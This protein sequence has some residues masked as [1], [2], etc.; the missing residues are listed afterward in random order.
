MF[1]ARLPSRS[2]RY[3]MAVSEESGSVSVR[4]KTRVTSFRGHVL[5]CSETDLPLDVI[6]YSVV[7]HVLISIRFTHFC[8]V[9]IAKRYWRYVRLVLTR[10]TKSLAKCLAKRLP[11]VFTKVDKFHTFDCRAALPLTLYS[12]PTSRRV[13]RD[14]S[15]MR[16]A[17]SAPG[18]IQ[19]A[20]RKNHSWPWKSTKV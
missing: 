3:Q 1:H 18:S 2:M 14:S 7:E 17:L 9:T 13:S 5:G 12:Q 20:F 10:R 16:T 11:N 15:E 4:C 8:T 6:K 19:V